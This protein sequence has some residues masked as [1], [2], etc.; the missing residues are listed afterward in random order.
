MIDTID[1]QYRGLSERN[2]KVSVLVNLK[3]YLFDYY[4]DK[5]FTK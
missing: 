1:S 4:P 2:M 5:N 3:K